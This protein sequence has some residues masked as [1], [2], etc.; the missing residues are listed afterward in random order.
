MKRISAGLLAVLMGL[1]PIFYIGAAA[2]EQPTLQPEGT[3]TRLETG[4]A[5]GEFIAI[6]QGGGL[7]AQLRLENQQDFILALELLR[8]DTG[9][10]VQR[11]TLAAEDFSYSWTLVIR[12]D[13]GVSM[14]DRDR[15]TLVVYDST[16]TETL[17]FQA[18]AA[19]G[20]AQAF[21]DS[22]GQFLYY[23]KDNRITRYQLPGGTAKEIPI[24][25][26]APW[27]FYE[28]LGE[29][30]GSLL[31][32]LIGMDALTTLGRMDKMGRVSLSPVPAGFE[33]M[34][35]SLALQASGDEAL[36]TPLPNSG[37]FTYVSGW[38]NGEHMLAYD[39]GL[40]LTGT[41]NGPD[42]LRLFDLEHGLLLNELDTAGLSETL[43]VDHALLSREGYAL[44]VLSNYE[45]EQFGLYR[46]DYAKE[47]LNRGSGIRLM[48]L[49]DIQREHDELA[50]TIA[51]RYGIG[52]FIRDKGAA[53][54]NETYQGTVLR[55]ELRLGTALRELDS[56]FAELPPGILNELL[57]PPYERFAAYLCGPIKPKNASG[58]SIASGFASGN[59]ETR[60]IAVNALDSG[61]TTNLAHEMMHVLEDRLWQDA[62]PGEDAP[63]SRWTLLSPEDAPD[64]GYAYSY[65]NPD[66]TDWY[67]D[68]YTL[69]WLDTE[70]ARADGIWF[71]DAYSRTYPL[72]DRARVFEHLFA[73]ENG[74]EV[75][76]TQPHLLLK[77]QSLSA[78]IRHA[79]PSVQGI[80]KAHWENFLTLLPY[81]TLLL[82]LSPKDAD[83]LPKGQADGVDRL[84]CQGENIVLQCACRVIRGFVP[85][86]QQDRAFAS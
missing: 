54:V 14:L 52:V 82:L 70:P 75:L 56:F 58:I 19:A 41:Y 18:P 48:P 86:A 77:A 57:V 23:A 46:W 81:D 26:P 60:Y 35:G 40:L 64:R 37:L 33:A 30:D 76:F 39:D 2:G 84:A 67:D 27:T 8:P 17:R 29:Q 38:R 72:E 78:F 9:E 59:Q 36:L 47:P 22:S 20:Y 21:A 50:A 53:F 6:A 44:I 4:G 25:L 80:Q 68:R 65:H 43:F 5:S 42:P 31:F 63:V 83:L 45:L 73:A 71:I 69:A 62:L 10:A 28:F 32:T 49:G 15:M 51:E 34:D 1:F 74:D 13:G 12:K 11:R 7:L 55:E 66:G 61:L 16:L 3:L 24:G 79:F 85:V